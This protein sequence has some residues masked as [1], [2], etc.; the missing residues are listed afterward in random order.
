MRRIVRTAVLFLFAGA[1]AAGCGPNNEQD[2]PEGDRCG[3][4][5]LA[6]QGDPQQSDPATC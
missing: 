4:S 6:Q 2:D 3:K 5:V 1:L